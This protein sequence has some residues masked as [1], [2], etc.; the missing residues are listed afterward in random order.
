MSYVD[1]KEI[2]KLKKLSDAIQSMIDRH[3]DYLISDQY[4]LMK[5]Q[6][7]I[8]YLFKSYFELTMFLW[9]ITEKYLKSKNVKKEVIDL[10]WWTLN[11]SFDI[12]IK[13]FPNT[14][15]YGFKKAFESRIEIYSSISK[16][17]FDKERTDLQILQW[18]FELIIDRPFSTN[19][20]ELDLIT[21]FIS[22]FGDL[23][24]MPYSLSFNQWLYQGAIGYNK[25]LHSLQL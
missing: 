21:T 16:S 23:D 2:S 14:P 15:Y 4:T 3:F 6:T 20:S 18:L 5:L 1:K 7:D 11:H 9:S 8:N 12:Y 22:N 10:L 25:T 24:K 19:V 13:S 17:Y